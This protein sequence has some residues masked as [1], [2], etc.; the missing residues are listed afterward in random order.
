MISQSG[1]EMILD[2]LMKNNTL[3]TL[4]VRKKK[5]IKNILNKQ[6]KYFLINLVRCSRR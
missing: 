6:E 2:E 1:L 5:K 4:D 3:E